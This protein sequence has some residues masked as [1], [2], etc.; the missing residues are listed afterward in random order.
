MSR[1]WICTCFCAN[2]KKL[3]KIDE[4]EQKFLLY[5]TSEVPAQGQLRLGFF[6]AFLLQKSL[7]IYF[8]Y[9]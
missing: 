6:Y 4:P 2:N 1:C 9:N 3:L 5:F 8:L 7:I